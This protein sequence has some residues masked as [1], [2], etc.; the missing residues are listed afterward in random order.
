MTPKHHLLNHIFSP[1]KFTTMKKFKNFFTKNNGKK[2]V[3]TSKADG[4]TFTYSPASEAVIKETEEAV[5]ANDA[6]ARNDGA[7]NLPRQ[8]NVFLSAPPKKGLVPNQPVNKSG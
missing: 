7:N 6:E 3:D 8:S 1:L 5:F 2:E 4:V